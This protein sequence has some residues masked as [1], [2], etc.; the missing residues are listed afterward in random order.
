[1]KSILVGCAGAVLGFIVGLGLMLGASQFLKPAVVEDI[2]TPVPAPV[3]ADVSITVS[4]ALL[5]TQLQQVVRQSGLAKQASVSLA[6]P[7]VVRAAMVVDTNVLGQR[8]SVNAT[9]TLRVS[10]QSGRIVLAVEKIDVGG[11]TIPQSMLASLVEQLRKQ[12]EDE[13]NRAAQRSLQGTGLRIVGVRMTASTLT[14]DL[15]RQ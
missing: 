14:V 11:V 15:T 3:S 8:L 13:I 4:A 2:S 7:N 5:N 6:A 9:V 1:M 12:A 10:V